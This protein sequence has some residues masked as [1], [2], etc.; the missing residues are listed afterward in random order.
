MW[1]APR[2]RADAALRWG[3][4]CGG[5]G[6]GS[7]VDIDYD[8]YPRINKVAGA[9]PAGVSWVPAPPDLVYAL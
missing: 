4:Q 9:N 7:S 6:G 8:A 3:S 2:K 5:G 1:L